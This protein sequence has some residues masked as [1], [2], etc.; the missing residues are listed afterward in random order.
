MSFKLLRLQFLQ[1]RYS[2]EVNRILLKTE[3]QATLF[4]LTQIQTVF[5]LAPLHLFKLKIQACQIQKKSL[6]EWWTMSKQRSGP[7]RSENN[8]QRCPGLSP[9]S[10][11]SAN[12]FNRKILCEKIRVPDR[13][14]ASTPPACPESTMNIWQTTTLISDV[15]QSLILT[16]T[17]VLKTCFD[18]NSYLL[19]TFCACF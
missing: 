5:M 10:L 12:P 19:S 17:I 13:H 9:T 1:A 4:V 11:Y 18:W 16:T 14:F 2:E 15:R 8:S 7:P 3:L 6:R